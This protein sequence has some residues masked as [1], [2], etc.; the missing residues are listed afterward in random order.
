MAHL[1]Q[2]LDE[3]LELR[4]SKESGQVTLVEPRSYCGCTV[5]QQSEREF[6]SEDYWCWDHLM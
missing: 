4:V 1:S 5:H 6:Q 3:Q 2:L